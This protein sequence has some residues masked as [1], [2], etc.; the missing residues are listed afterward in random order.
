VGAP[1]RERRERPEEFCRCARVDITRRILSERVP[2]SFIAAIS[3]RPSPLKPRY[4]S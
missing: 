2:L 3:A 1:A 4:R